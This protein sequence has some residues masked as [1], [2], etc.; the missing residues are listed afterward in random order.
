MTTAQNSFKYNRFL[1]R[2]FPYIKLYWFRT[3]LI[4]NTKKHA[5]LYFNSKYA[6]SWDK[7]NSKKANYG[8][9]ENNKNQV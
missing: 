3:F 2:I 9:K 4:F 8:T 5:E 1:S 7:P 6:T